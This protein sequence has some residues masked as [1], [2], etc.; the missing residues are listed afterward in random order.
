MIG[1]GYGLLLESGDVLPIPAKSL[2]AARR[3]LARCNARN[4]EC[5]ELGEVL[6]PYLATGL[7]KPKRRVDPCAAHIGRMGGRA[8]AASLTAERRSEIARKA[9]QTRWNIDRDTGE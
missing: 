8:R 9:A 1:V 6:R 4:R 2:S 3:T 5:K 7:V